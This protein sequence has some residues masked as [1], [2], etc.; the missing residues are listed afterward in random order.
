MVIV[1]V[2]NGS[3]MADTPRKQI[4]Y[5]H[6]NKIPANK[7]QLVFE[8]RGRRG[9]VV[10]PVRVPVGRH[11]LPKVHPFVV[12][13]PQVHLHDVANVQVGGVGRRRRCLH[14]LPPWGGGTSFVEMSHTNRNECG[15]GKTVH[16]VRFDLYIFKMV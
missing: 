2:S 1:V 8:D 14:E 10:F 6:R 13:Q 16:T 11:V 4:V 7:S 12:G 15:A 3:K 9:L 5:P